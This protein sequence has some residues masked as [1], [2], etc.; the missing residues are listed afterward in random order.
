[1][2]GRG[3]CRRWVS[4]LPNA[5]YF[6]PNMPYRE[7]V[8]ILIEEFEAF[9][10][11]DYLGLTQHEA[12][13]RMGVSQKTLWNDLKNARFKIA[14]AIINGKGIKIEGGSYVLR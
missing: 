6:I 7:T 1:M 4:M 13:I 2:P 5:N 3:R 11:V 9:R 14:D 12:A 8:I 10:L